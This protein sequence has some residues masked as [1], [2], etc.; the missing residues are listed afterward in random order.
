MALY[1]YQATYTPEAV[2]AQINNP[3]DRIEAV[4][5]AIEDLGGKI[6]A[7]GYSFGEYDVLFIYE[8]SD[9]TAAAGFALAVAA[10]GAVRAAK[11]TR[12]LTSGEWVD[13]LRKAQGSPY[14]PVRYTSMW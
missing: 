11:T 5:P 4:R 2:A 13:S 3:Q 1:M 7:G 6:L 14:Q 10:G 9:D 8:A 12:L